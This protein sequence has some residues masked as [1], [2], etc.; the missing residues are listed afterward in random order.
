MA[1]QIIWRFREQ[2]IQVNNKENVNAKSSKL[3]ALCEG[4]PLVNSGFPS[5][6]ASNEETS[7]VISPNAPLDIITGSPTFATNY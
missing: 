1:S 2:L 7:H 5:Q 3:I 6:R 4:N